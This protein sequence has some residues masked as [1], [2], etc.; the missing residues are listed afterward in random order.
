M[1]EYSLRLLSRPKG[2]RRPYYWPQSS[3]VE[4]LSYRKCEIP[5]KMPNARNVS[6]VTVQVID[7]RVNDCVYI[8]YTSSTHSCAIAKTN[9][10]KTQY[11]RRMTICWLQSPFGRSKIVFF[12]FSFATMSTWTILHL[13]KWG[14][15]FMWRL[16]RQTSFHHSHLS[17]HCVWL[18]AHTYAYT[19][20]SNAIHA[21]ELFVASALL[22]AI[23]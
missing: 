2:V 10:S 20:T 14:V 16:K 12:A 6:D 17:S 9:S 8:L 5:W 21:Q 7:R 23:A 4:P 11:Y 3:A 22:V 19:L 18:I 15:V 1:V 13:R